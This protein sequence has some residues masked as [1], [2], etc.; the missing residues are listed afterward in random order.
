MFDVDSKDVFDGDS[1]DVGSTMVWY[2]FDNCH[3]CFDSSLIL[4]CVNGHNSKAFFD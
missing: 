1:I 2:M 4:S 3:I